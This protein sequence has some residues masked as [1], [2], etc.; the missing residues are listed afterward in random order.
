MTCVHT[1]RADVG[2]LGTRRVCIITN[3]DCGV[4]MYYIRNCPIKADGRCTR[5][6]N[7][8]RVCY[9]LDLILNFKHIEKHS[10]RAVY[11]VCTSVDRFCN[12]VVHLHKI[13]TY[14]YK[15]MPQLNAVANLPINFYVQRMYHVQ[16][17]SIVRTAYVS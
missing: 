16:H 9:K 8:T 12:F 1:S 2:S 3:T 11:Y 14:T 10:V 4:C 13:S 5:A 15:T 6:Q 17:T 7:N